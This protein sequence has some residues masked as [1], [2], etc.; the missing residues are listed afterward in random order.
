VGVWGGVRCVCDRQARGAGGPVCLDAPLG[1]GPRARVGRANERVEWRAAVWPLPLPARP[2]CRL[3]AP[4][5][6]R[7]AA[8]NVCA[9]LRAS[10]EAGRGA[11][12]AGRAPTSRA[13]LKKKKGG[14][15]DCAFFRV[16]CSPPEEKK[17]KKR[18]PTRSCGALPGAAAPAHPTKRWAR[19]QGPPF[20]GGR[21]PGR[22]GR[23]A[24]RRAHPAR[25]S[26]RSSA[27]ARAPSPLG[28]PSRRAPRR[29]R[30]APP[31]A[32]RPH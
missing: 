20:W 27:H 26:T 12:S 23:Q 1:A 2:D 32:P 31:A 3:S 17:K 10:L 13:A 18:Q 8:C 9:G 11:D 30:P 16:A 6:G 5:R 4:T 28:R 21:R 7:D 14:G 25:N 24:A 29:A 15:V 22:G 19:S